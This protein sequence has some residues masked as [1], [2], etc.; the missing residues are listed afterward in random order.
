MSSYTCHVVNRPRNSYQRLNITLKT[1]GMA[2]PG[3]LVA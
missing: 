2:W 1:L 3:I